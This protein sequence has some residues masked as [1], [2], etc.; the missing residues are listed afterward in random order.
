[1]AKIWPKKIGH[2]LNLQKFKDKTI[3][4]LYLFP[5]IIAYLQKEFHLKRSKS[6]PE[7]DLE[8]SLKS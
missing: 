5:Y 7:K 6:R 2:P 3:P 4:L 8:V 1:M